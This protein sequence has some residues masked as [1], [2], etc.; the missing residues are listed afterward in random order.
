MVFLLIIIFISKEYPNNC[1]NLTTL[2]SRLC[3]YAQTAPIYALQVKQMLEGRLR[4][5]KN[6]ENDFNKSYSTGN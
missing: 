2:L 3:A 1:F 4:R 6:V 5:K